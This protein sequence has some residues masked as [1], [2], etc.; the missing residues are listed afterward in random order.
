VVQVEMAR[1]VVLRDPDGRQVGA[2]ELASRLHVKLAPTALFLGPGGR[3]LA[4]RMVGVG[5]EDFYDSL[6]Q[7]RLADA[8]RAAGWTDGVRR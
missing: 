7:Q 5:A 3:E 1:D 2:R 4:E 6:V 8:R